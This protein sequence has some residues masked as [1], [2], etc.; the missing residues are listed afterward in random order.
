MASYS[1][2]AIEKVISCRCPVIVED[3]DGTVSIG[4]LTH[5]YGSALHVMPININESIH[6][7]SRT[8]IKSI[9]NFYGFVYPKSVEP[10]ERLIIKIRGPIG[11]EAMAELIGRAGYRYV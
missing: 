11:L 7:V 9:V 3:K 6:A 5:G 8:R 2:D 4:Y 10:A 1:K